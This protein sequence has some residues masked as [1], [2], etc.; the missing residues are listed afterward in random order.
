MSPTEAIQVLNDLK[1][2]GHLTGFKL[3]CPPLT[4]HSVLVFT[5]ANLGPERRDDGSRYPEL[6]VVC[7]GANAGRALVAGAEEAREWINPTR[8][9]EAAE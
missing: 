2:S 4:E 8:A 6:V 7:G 1:Y 5:I 9:P 3:I